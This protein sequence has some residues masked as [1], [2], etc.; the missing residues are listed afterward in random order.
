MGRLAAGS[1]RV[2]IDMDIQ[3]LGP[4]RMMQRLQEF[5]AQ[6]AGA[7][8]FQLPSGVS[9]LSGNAP[10]ANGFA[11]FN[12]KGLGISIQADQAPTGLKG[13]IDEAAN[14][15]GIDPALLD[16]VVATESSYDPKCR[17]R[18]GAMGLTQL[19]PDNVKELG[20]K[21]PYDPRENLQGGAKQLSQLLAKYP[22]RIDLALAAYNAG[23]GAVAKYGGVPPYTETK[24]Y[25]TKVMNLYN[26]RK[27]QP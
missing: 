2:R 5:Q 10:D 11:P 27:G 17:S 19:M 7:P 25:I 3:P 20:V 6:S 12:P 4:E 26:A 14:E 24:N 15:N 8:A 22:G 1:D 21:N 9:G 16:A 23:P 13:L 18:A